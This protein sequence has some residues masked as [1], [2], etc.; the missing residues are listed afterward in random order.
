[1]ATAS[2]KDSQDGAE[3][4]AEEDEANMIDAVPGNRPQKWLEGFCDL[5]KDAFHLVDAFHT[6]HEAG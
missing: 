3:D 6:R 1:M 4:A 5:D 2:L